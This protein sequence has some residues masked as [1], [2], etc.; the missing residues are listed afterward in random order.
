MMS[1]RH[2][3][4]AALTV[5]GVLASVSAA[6]W[7]HG[8]ESATKLRAQIERERNPVRKAKLE[9]RLADLDLQRAANSYNHNQPHQA[10]ALLVDYLKDMD[11]SWTV[12]EDS[13]RNPVKKPAGFMS[14]EIA[15][16]ENARFLNE[17]RENVMYAYQ[18]PIKTLVGTIDKLHSKVLLVLFPGAL[19][20]APGALKVGSSAFAAKT[21]QP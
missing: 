12:L 13:G 4:L 17:L 5:V 15:L 18:E 11:S 19:P 8:H 6:A 14:L 16:R 9:I 21:H 3:S 2:A 1:R 20:P 10:K 7:G